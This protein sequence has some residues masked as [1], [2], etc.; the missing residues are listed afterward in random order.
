MA[1]IA[2]I[3]FLLKN[4]FNPLELV[5]VVHQ[6]FIFLVIGEEQIG[7]LGQAEH[8]H[9]EEIED[10]HQGDADEETLEEGAPLDALVGEVEREDEAV[11]AVGGQDDGGDETDGEEGGVLVAHDVVDGVGDGAQN[12]L[13]HEAFQVG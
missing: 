4:K 13:G 7:F 12:L 10:E 1:A 6:H 3:F 9:H 2:A 8:Q 11:H 5:S